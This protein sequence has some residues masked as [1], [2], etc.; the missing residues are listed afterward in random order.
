MNDLKNYENL[1]DWILDSQAGRLEGNGLTGRPT[2]LTSGPTVPLLGS[3][4]VCFFVMT[5]KVHLT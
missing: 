2:G 3:F 5:P 4:G 1:E